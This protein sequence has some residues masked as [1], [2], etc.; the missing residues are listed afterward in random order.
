[1]SQR[2]IDFV[3]ML[4]AHE[5][6]WEREADYWSDA[7]NRTD[8]KDECDENVKICRKWAADWRAL[9]EA[10]KAMVVAATNIERSAICTGR[11]EYVISGDDL[12]TLE[13]ALQKARA[14]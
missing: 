10:W 5:C 8:S 13:A 11:D 14:T 9:R 7:K 1:M 6:S 2:A 4:R 12:R 3:E